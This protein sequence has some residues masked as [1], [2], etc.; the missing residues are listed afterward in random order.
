MLV[1]DRR[2]LENLFSRSHML[3]ATHCEHEQTIEH[4]LVRFQ[5]KYGDAIPFTAHPEI[6][7]HE[8]CFLSSSTAVELAKAHGTRLHI[9]HLTTARE[10]ELFDNKTPLTQKRITSEVCVHHLHF[11]DED[12]PA[13]GALIKC[14]PAIKSPQDR[15]ALWA[16]LLED[17]LDIIATDHAPHTWEEKQGDYMHA[18][19]GLPLVQHALVL[20]LQKVLAGRLTLE[21]MVEKM[22]HA[23]A[24][25]FRMPDRGYLDE[26]TYADLVVVDPAA[27]WTVHQEGLFYKCKW[28]PLEGVQMV[29]NV[30]QT[31]VNGSLVYDRGKIVSETPG[32]RLAFTPLS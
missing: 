12:Y 18:P 21:K 1:D 20:M 24:D 30:V 23:P 22:C 14:N 29:G 6:R 32:M 11:S 5:A 25:C 4:N 26:G 8:A 27:E 13:M 3:I 31:Y 19:S 9:L 16:G 17:K 2:T 10:L 28:S 7:S 15:E